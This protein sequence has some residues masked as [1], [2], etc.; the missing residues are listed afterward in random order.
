MVFCTTVPPDNKL[1]TTCHDNNNDNMPSFTFR[2]ILPHSL[3]IAADWFFYRH[4]TQTIDHF[5]GIQWYYDFF[6]HT[7]SSLETETKRL[8]D[9]LT[10]GLKKIS[11]WGQVKRIN[12]KALEMNYCMLTTKLDNYFSCGNG[13]IEELKT[14]EIAVALQGSMLA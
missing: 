13:N 11:E 5:C 3:S 1:L 7:P 6:G 9:F 4:R 8:N 12:Y 10:S 14:L 2:L